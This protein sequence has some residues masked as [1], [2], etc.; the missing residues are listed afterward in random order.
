MEAVNIIKN[1]INNKE[2]SLIPS[3]NLAYYE[4]LSAIIEEGNKLRDDHLE[5]EN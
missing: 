4:Q 3:M 2:G 1:R 5:K